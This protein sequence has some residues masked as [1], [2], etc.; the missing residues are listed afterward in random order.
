MDR[1]TPE[2]RSAN[3]RAVRKKDTAPELAVRK[4]LHVAG[5]RYRIHVKNLPGSPDIV[6]PRRKKV[7]FVHGCFWHGHNCRAGRAPQSRQDYWIPK[8]ER[9]RARDAAAIE[10]LSRQGWMS[11]VVWQC[12]LSNR[13]DALRRMK[14]FL[15]PPGHRL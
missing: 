15:G 5:Y 14:D 9:N 10:T 8:I 12:Q 7:I 2:A 11:L 3:M 4:A 6:F 13:D 1:I